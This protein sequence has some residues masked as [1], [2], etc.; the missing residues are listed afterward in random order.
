[1]N[2]RKIVSILLLLTLILMPFTG[3]LIHINHG[4]KAEH[5]FLHFHFLSGVIFVIV[6][7][8]HLIL[9]WKAFKKYLTNK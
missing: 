1:M 9:N 2:K 4:Q 5:S 3:I 6:G 7:I 8:I